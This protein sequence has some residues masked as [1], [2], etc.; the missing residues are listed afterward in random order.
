MMSSGDSTVITKKVNE[1]HLPQNKHLFRKT[2]LHAGILAYKLYYKINVLFQ[3]YPQY[4]HSYRNNYFQT[5]KRK[6]T[7]SPSFI[8]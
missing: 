5:L 2:S 3:S 6:S 8:T 4:S 1:T 7:T